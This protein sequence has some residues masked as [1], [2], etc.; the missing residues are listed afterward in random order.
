[1]EYW[2]ITPSF[3]VSGQIKIT[4]I[5]SLKNQGFTDIICNRPCHESSTSEKPDLIRKVANQNDIDFHNNPFPGNHLSIT[6]V[7]QQKVGGDKTLA[8]CTS[9]IRS[10]VL[11][12]FSMAGDITTENILQCL[13]DAGFPMPHLADQI[14][15]FALT[16]IANEG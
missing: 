9:G 4:D 6:S 11:W 13:S 16:K 2:K 8:Y 14:E 12:A 1:M 3:F 7:S 10:A 15:G 5:K